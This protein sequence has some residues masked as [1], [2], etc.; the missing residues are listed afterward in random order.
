MCAF[1][2]SLFAYKLICLLLSLPYKKK[3]REKFEE[4][5]TALEW[6]SMQQP[7]HGNRDQNAG[8][9]ELFL[10]PELFPNTFCLVASG[11]ASTKVGKGFHSSA[12]G[13]LLSAICHTRYSSNTDYSGAVRS[14]H[15]YHVRVED[16]W[17][18]HHGRAQVS[19][20]NA[21]GGRNGAT[22]VYTPKTRPGTTLVLLYFQVECFDTRGAIFARSLSPKQTR[23]GILNKKK[24]PPT[25]R[26]NRPFSE[27]R[28]QGDLASL[29]LR[30]V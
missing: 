13:L 24:K 12:C 11:G 7:I 10:T 23:H 16:T 5:Y 15:R 20:H 22:L 29:L 26:P 25:V 17:G 9:S 28:L 2:Y 3:E 14:V 30:M 4:S 19:M 21:R 8:Y 1:C 6:F 27:A 18:A